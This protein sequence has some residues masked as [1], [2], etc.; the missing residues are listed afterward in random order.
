MRVLNTDEQEDENAPI[1][2]KP[3]PQV[4]SATPTPNFNSTIPNLKRD[5]K[6][7]VES[8]R[9]LDS[10]KQKLEQLQNHMKTVFTG[11][12]MVN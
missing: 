2:D 1:Y 12:Y 9:H 7:I 6:M 8:T 10:T 5:L 11:P 3:Y 4:N